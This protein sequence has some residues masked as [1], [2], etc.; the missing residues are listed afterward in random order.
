MRVIGFFKKH[1]L[2]TLSVIL[3]LVFLAATVAGRYTISPWKILALIGEKLGFGPANVEHSAYT[4]FWVI[5][6]PR[7]LCAM[8]VGAGLACAGAVFQGVFKNPMTSPDILGAATGAGFG[9]A[10]GILNAMSIVAVQAMSFV[11]GIV[12]VLMTCLVA[13]AVD[14]KSSTTITLIL[15]GMVV[16]AL[17]QA[18]ISITKYVADPNST[19]PSI[20]LWLMGTFSGL[21]WDDAKQLGIVMAVSL[22]PMFLCRWRLSVLAMGDEEAKTLGVNADLLRA[23]MIICATLVTSTTVAFCGVIG[24]IG[25][26]VPHM[27][28]AIVGAD[29]SKLLPASALAGAG[30]ALAVDI[31]AHSLMQLELPLGILTALIGAPFFLFLLK[32]GKRGWA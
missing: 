17:F 27:A 28:R 4:A 18:G 30:F 22:L 10:L 5:R 13:R 9:A 25:L 1:Y 15:V 31:V 8:I 3:V 19:L 29:F 20:T 16:S 2:I 32:R 11:G 12:A 24:W 21:H 14:R 26:I 6:V 23:I 7:N